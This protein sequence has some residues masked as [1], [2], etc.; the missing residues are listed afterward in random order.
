[1]SSNQGSTQWSAAAL[2][3]NALNAWLKPGSPLVADLHLA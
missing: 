2:V 3:V 1:M